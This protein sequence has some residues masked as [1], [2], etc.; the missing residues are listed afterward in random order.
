MSVD[1]PPGPAPPAPAPPISPLDWK[2]AQAIVTG[3][4]GLA[5]LGV[6]VYLLGG[7][8]A[9]L[10]V[11]AARLPAGNVTAAFEDRALVTAGI[12]VAGLRGAVA[13]PRLGGDRRRPRD[14]PTGR[15]DGAAPDG[16]LAAPLQPSRRR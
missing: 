13:L 7:I 15:T 11:V 12:K 8:V 1:R 5:G 10:R 3:L 16:R 4:A 2:R 6:Y 14:R 9:W